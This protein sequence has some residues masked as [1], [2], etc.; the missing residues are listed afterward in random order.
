MAL[1]RA[2]AAWAASEASQKRMET[3][4]DAVSDAFISLDA[5]MRFTYFNAAAVS[6]CLI[7]G[8]DP[9]DL[10]GQVLGDDF[11]TMLGRRIASEARRVMET[12]LPADFEDYSDVQN[13]WLQVR[14]FPAEDGGV[15]AYSQDVTARREV[16]AVREALYQKDR[17]IAETLQR[18]LLRV[19]SAD[20]F[21]PL[22]I[23]TFYETA[24]D[25]A[26]IG[27][28]FFDVFRLGLDRVALIV[29]NTSGKGLQAA[30]MTAQVKYALRL[31]PREASGPGVTLA[32]LNDFVCEAQR[33]GDAGTDHQVTLTLTTVT[34]ATGETVTASAGGKPALYL[35]ADGSQA[36]AWTEGLLLG[37]QPGIVYTEHHTRLSAG[38]TLL[39]VT[40]GITEAHRG[41]VWLGP[42]GLSA[43]IVQALACETLHETGRVLLDGARA[44]AGGA[45]QDDA[46]LLLV[47]W[48]G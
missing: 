6:N 14:V 38:D 20:A 11:Q 31:L 47:R 33:S 21:S 15:V 44:W 24:S 30:E 16:E 29:G 26:Q 41:G 7:S 8:L 3:L 35:S 23:E 34:M 19:D 36:S 40:S 4:L 37:I 5:E 42:E 27:G 17:R 22:T 18:A 1:A 46:C 28:D 48:G 32:R 43:L 25:E 10:L 39:L 45:L 12:G 2:Q 9:T 13:R